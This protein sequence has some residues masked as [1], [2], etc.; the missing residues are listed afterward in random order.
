MHDCLQGNQTQGYAAGTRLRCRQRQ[1]NRRNSTQAKGIPTT[2][3]QTTKQCR[4]QRTLIPGTTPC[5]R[6]TLI[7][8]N[9]IWYI[10]TRTKVIELTM[11]GHETNRSSCTFRSW[12]CLDRH[13]TGFFSR[14]ATTRHQMLY[15]CI[16]G[17]VHSFAGLKAGGT[18]SLHHQHQFSTGS[19]HLHRSK[20]AKSYVVRPSSWQKQL[21]Y[22]LLVRSS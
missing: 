12:H 6:T 2:R 3:P 13:S 15:G 1:H 14:R 22:L 4:L 20:N 11:Q 19:G 16:H 18:R 17:S 7:P 5:S 9:S 8:D 21:P 10:E